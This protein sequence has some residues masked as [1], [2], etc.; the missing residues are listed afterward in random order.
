MQYSKAI[1]MSPTLLQGTMDRK[2][3]LSQIYQAQAWP[4]FP[5]HSYEQGLQPNQ[6]GAPKETSAVTGLSLGHHSLGWPVDWK[7]QPR[8]YPL[9]TRTQF[10]WTVTQET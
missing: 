7:A 3:L 5:A 4:C 2:R 9:C 8:L 6:Q 1:S 10:P